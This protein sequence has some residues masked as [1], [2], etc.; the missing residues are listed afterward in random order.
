MGLVNSK[1]AIDPQVFVFACL[2][3][4][5]CRTVFAVILI[6]ACLSHP[7]LSHAQSPLLD[8][9]KRGAERTLR[10]TM[11][12]PQPPA[13]PSS[14]GSSATPGTGR[15]GSGAPTTKDDV[16]PRNAA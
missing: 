4:G 14:S 3:G 2:Q 6:S 8:E 9:L 11:R 15:A 1:P 10:D 12:A 5:C 16:P 13:P 7:G